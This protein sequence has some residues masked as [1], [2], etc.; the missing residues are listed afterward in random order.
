MELRAQ[1]EDGRQTIGM[2][3]AS[4]VRARSDKAIDQSI[5]FAKRVLARI[6]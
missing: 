3:A 5:E 2:M 1:V 4:L 6:D